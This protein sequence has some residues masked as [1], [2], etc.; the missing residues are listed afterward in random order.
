MKNIFFTLFFYNFIKNYWRDKKIG[1]QSDYM[2][3][4][5]FWNWTVH[6]GFTNTEQHNLKELKNFEIDTHFKIETHEWELSLYQNELGL[7][8]YASNPWLQE[9]P[10]A[11]TKV[12]WDNYITRHQVIVLSYLILIVLILRQHGTVYILVRKKKPLLLF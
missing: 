2:T 11:V 7:G 9:L 8:Q 10:S 6:N 12:V 4:D 5:E 1:N 3:F